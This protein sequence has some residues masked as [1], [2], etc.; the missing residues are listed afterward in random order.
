M[1]LITC[2]EYSLFRLLILD[3]RAENVYNIVYII[4]YVTNK[5]IAEEIITTAPKHLNNCLRDDINASESETIK[6]IIRLKEFSFIGVCKVDSVGRNYE[7]YKLVQEAIR[8]SLN[9]GKSSTINEK[10]IILGHGSGK[11]TEI[12]LC[13]HTQRIE[14]MGMSN[15]EHIDGEKYFSSI[16]PQATADRFPNSQR[17][18]WKQCG[19]FL[20][21]CTAN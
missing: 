14:L 10:N 17:D 20:A 9:M 2:L 11:E 21:T 16:A 6:I 3:K 4:A 5:N 7:M 13:R 15:D 19:K 1:C 8:H 12:P 18:T